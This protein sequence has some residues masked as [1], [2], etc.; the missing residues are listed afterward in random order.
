MRD[1]IA[2][3]A[4][5]DELTVIS[6]PVDPKFELA[7][8]TH[9]L[10]Q[11][12]DKAILFENVS[13]SAMPVITNVFGSRARLCQLIGAEDGNFCRRWHELYAAIG[14]QPYPPAKVAPEARTSGKLGDLPL[15]TYFE[16]DGGASW[17]AKT[18]RRPVGVKL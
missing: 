14:K 6:T 1:Y 5:R 13:G 16:K 15:I 17:Q 4:E 12:S 9:R 3:L 11:L 18:E 2:R 8:V 10:Q 7:A